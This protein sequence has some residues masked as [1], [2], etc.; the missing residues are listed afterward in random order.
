MAFVLD[1]WNVRN[2][3]IKQNF[4]Q[5]DLKGTRLVIRKGNP[6]VTFDLLKVNVPDCR[7]IIILGQDES[8]I[9][10]SDA[11][12]LRIIMSLKGLRQK[13]KGHIV[14][15]LQD[16][17]NRTIVELIGARTVETVISHE[18][19]G[20]LMLMASRQPGLAVV[21]DA[22]FGYHGTEFFFK[23]GIDFYFIVFR[24]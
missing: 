16:I 14:A 21:Y 7:S 12:I 1:R 9:E 13:L 15:E 10:K 6:I 19:S 3:E 20:R 17:D 8:N 11:K 23:D 24:I 4:S 2:C 5:Q 22:V 18:I